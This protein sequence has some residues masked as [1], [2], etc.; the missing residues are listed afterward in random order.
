MKQC[1]LHFLVVVTKMVG[2]VWGSTCAFL[3]L[4]EA[5]PSTYSS[6]SCGAQKVEGKDKV[7]DKSE[8]WKGE[9]EGAIK[10]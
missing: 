8:H 3:E 6:S 9:T 5:V 10:T 2:W 7:G 4:L 1:L